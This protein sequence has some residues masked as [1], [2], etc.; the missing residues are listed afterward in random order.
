MGTGA[1]ESLPT[2][3]KDL[4][5]FVP[6]WALAKEMDR[7]NARWTSTI[8][9]L[10]TFYDA[11]L[12]RLDAIIDHLN[13][14]S[15]DEMPAAEKRLLRLS[16]SMAE[17]ADAVETFGVPEVPYSFDPARYPPTGQPEEEEN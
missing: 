15:L 3:F 17:I 1:S 4:E 11:M 14:F 5:T 16:L 10:R 12:P 2:G 7:I 9:E 6:K 13:R 8:E